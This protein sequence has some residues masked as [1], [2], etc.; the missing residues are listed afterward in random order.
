MNINCSNY[1]MVEVKGLERRNGEILCTALSD[2]KVRSCNSQDARSY[3][4]YTKTALH[5][6]DSPNQKCSA[7][8]FMK[9]LPSVK[10]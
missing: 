9:P 1:S 10:L 7:L 2:N 6:S 5:S 4:I 8:P 3:L